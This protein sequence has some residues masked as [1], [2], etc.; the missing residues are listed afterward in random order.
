VPGLGA[1]FGRGGSTTFVQDLVNSDCILIEGSNFA[2]CHPVAFRFVMEA[3]ERGA[4]IVHVDPR[5]TRTSAVADIYAPIRSGTDIVFLGALINWVL[6][7]ERYFKEYVLAYTNA[8]YLVCEDFA[9]TEDLDGLFSG[10]TE[11]SP[12]EEG[13]GHDRGSMGLMGKD[14]VA[15]GAG[16]YDTSTWTFEMEE[17]PRFDGQ[18][19]VK[20]PKRDETFAHPRCVINVLR[21]HFSR[22]TPQMVEDV[23]GMPAATMERIAGI[24]AENSGRERT[25]S[26]AYAVGWTQHTVGV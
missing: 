24:L 26:F 12:A 15:P 9:D 17:V 11:G 22:Y 1:S 14:A 13:G 25:T 7:N 5:Y 18:G 3:K 20:V 4:T 2:E 23:C 8:S 19:T 10:W 21:R 6:A 16:N